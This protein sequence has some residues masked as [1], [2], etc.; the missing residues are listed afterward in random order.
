MTLPYFKFYRIPTNSHTVAFKDS[1]HR[2]LHLLLAEPRVKMN[3][4]HAYYG[5]NCASSY[6]H[7]FNRF[8]V[9][10]GNDI[11][12]ERLTFILQL[13]CLRHCI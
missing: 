12:K 11:C 3:C 6:L 10:C 4:L 13:T 1:C 9:V 7:D 5:I 2:Q 8:V